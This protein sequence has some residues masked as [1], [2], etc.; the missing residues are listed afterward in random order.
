M[1][2]TSLFDSIY[3]YELKPECRNGIKSPK[4]K[5]LIQ[6]TITRFCSSHGDTYKSCFQQISNVFQDI[7]KQEK[8]ILFD[9]EKIYYHTYCILT[10]LTQ[11]LSA[12]DYYYS[13]NYKKTLAG[14]RGSDRQLLEKFHLHK[15]NTLD[16]SNAFAGDDRL[17][18]SVFYNLYRDRETTSLFLNFFTFFPLQMCKVP[19]SDQW[20][21]PILQKIIEHF[22]STY[23]A[24]EEIIYKSLAIRL[25]SYLRSSMCIESGYSKHITQEILEELF[26]Y[27]FSATSA[28]LQR[29]VYIAGRLNSLPI[30]KHGKSPRKVSEK[31]INKFDD[32]INKIYNEF[33]DLENTKITAKEFLNEDIVKLF[34]THKPVEFLQEKQ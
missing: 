9:N 12:L 26:K 29:N 6:A 16:I 25:N 3:Q 22:S 14:L 13:D 4:S 30:F 34:L 23:I 21:T 1:S 15:A 8:V 24:S 31:T 32:F 33:N 18:A 17:K 7:Q 20:C 28:D 10:L 19:E 11:Y 27:K 5:V 2:K